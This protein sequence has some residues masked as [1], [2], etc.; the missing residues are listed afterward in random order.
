MAAEER[1]RYRVV[2]PEQ[3]KEGYFVLNG[4]IAH[5]HSFA[6]IDKTPEGNYI[7]RE[8]GVDNEASEGTLRKDGE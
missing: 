2:T 1:Q 8:P 3:L 7:V 4:V 6:V 5:R